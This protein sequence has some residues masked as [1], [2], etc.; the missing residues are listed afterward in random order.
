MTANSA[1]EGQPESS[2]DGQTNNP[3]QRNSDH[4]A[5]SN[6][7]GMNDGKKSSDDIKVA[8]T[9]TNA[10]L[11]TQL[12]QRMAY[13]RARGNGA[14]HGGSKTFLAQRLTA[15]ALI[16]LAIWFVVSLMVAMTG[17]GEA[18]AVWL[19]QPINAGLLAA[20]ILIALKHATI[21]VQVI[22]EDYVHSAGTLAVSKV[23]LYGVALT[24]ALATVAGL[25]V[26]LF[27]SIAGA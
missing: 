25:I 18:A 4:K 17:P 14:S 8:R 23:L 2:H 7:D 19:A 24:T 15:V 16:P 26:V 6:S 22:L 11:L 21:G 5:K 27:Q 3:D 12:E 20:L 1:K 9:Q 10:A 13:R